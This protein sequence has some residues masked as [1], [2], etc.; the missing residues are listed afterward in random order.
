MKTRDIVLLLLGGTFLAYALIPKRG[1]EIV[2][3]IGS[4]LMPSIRFPDIAFPSVNFPGISILTE[5]APGFNELASNASDLLEAPFDFIPDASDL[6]D[7]LV[8]II[9]DP[10]NIFTPAQAWKPAPIPSVLAR[11]NLMIESGGIGRIAEAAGLP[12]LQPGA[13]QEYF[14]SLTEFGQEE[15]L[16]AWEKM[17][18]GVG[19][20]E[21]LA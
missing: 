4:G 7:E 10:L 3:G 12:S 6:V 11:G 19:F 9:P 16:A 15:Q 5:I 21:E 18:G 13:Y 17:A 2:Q 8:S 14:E 1:Q 20:G